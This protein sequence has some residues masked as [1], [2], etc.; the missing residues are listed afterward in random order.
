MI[1]AIVCGYNCQ[2]TIGTCIDSIKM[3]TNNKYKL[4]KSIE[5]DSNRKYLLKN[6]VDT[7]NGIKCVDEDIIALI[8]ADDWLCDENAF[9]IVQETYDHYPDILLTYGSYVELST[10]RCGKFCSQYTQGEDFRK[11]P[12]RGSHLKTFK[13]KL[14]KMLPEL[15]LTDENGDYF[16]CCADRALMIPMMEMAGFD[17]IM[18]IPMLIYCYNDINPERVWKTMKDLSISTRDYISRQKPLERLDVIW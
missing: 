1:Q 8:D 3:Q 4:T 11:T 10:N 17:R 16:K 5:D 15:E 14:F 13:Y 18:H 7:I 9:K 2:K 6:T 12:W